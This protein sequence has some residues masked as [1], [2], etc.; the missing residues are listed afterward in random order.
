[1]SALKSHSTYFQN[2]FMIILGL[3]LGICV[4]SL[5]GVLVVLLVARF[6]GRRVQQPL[7]RDVEKGAATTTSNIIRIRRLYAVLVGVFLF[8][9]E[10]SI[11]VVF[12]DMASFYLLEPAVA[13]VLALVCCAPTTVSITLCFS[14]FHWPLSLLAITGECCLFCKTSSSPQ[15][16][17]ESPK[18]SAIGPSP[19]GVDLEMSTQ[20]KFREQDGDDD[21]YTL[22]G[23]SVGSGV[24]T[25]DSTPTTNT[26]IQHQPRSFTVLELVGIYWKGA[27]SA[28]IRAPIHFMCVAVSTSAGLAFVVFAM[29]GMCYCSNPSE[30]TT[31]LSRKASTPL[32]AEDSFCHLYALLGVDHSRMRVVGHVVVSGEDGPSGTTIRT[33]K[34]PL[35]PS[36]GGRYQE[37]DACD[38]SDVLSSPVSGTIVY[39]AHISEDLRYLAHHLLTGLEPT[40]VYKAVVEI[41][42]NNGVTLQKTLVFNTMPSRVNDTTTPVHFISGG[43]YYSGP[44]G[45]AMIHHVISRIPDLSFVYVGGD[46]SYSNNIRTCYRRMDY[47][48]R[49][50]SS[51]KRSI[52]GA[53]LPLLVIPGNHESGGYLKEDDNWSRYFFY[54]EY[55]PHYDD[56][57]PATLLTTHHM[58]YV[59][60]NLAIIGLDSGLMETVESQ[61][62]YLKTSL[63]AAMDGYIPPTDLSVAATQIPPATAPFVIVTYHNPAYPSLRPFSDPQSEDVRNLF[64]PQ[65]D[66]Y[67]VPLVLEF[68]DHAYKRTTPV[69]QNDVAA[70]GKGAIYVGDGGIGIDRDVQND[71]PAEHND[72][73]VQRVAS[74]NVQAITIFPNR[75]CRLST[76]DADGDVIDEIYIN[77]QII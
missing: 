8:G 72:L 29:Y 68:H 23:A 1:M 60:A 48:V 24:A 6:C 7:A 77:K 75:T 19:S 69:F 41:T 4:M 57:A 39:H 10:L 73:Y 37:T 18:C 62:D 15:E 28:C 66:R 21:F 26:K 30:F 63:T 51:L 3:A 11:A 58:H 50:F 36:T 47:F 55:F 32:C 20:K 53:N 5:V 27:L 16:S 61:V 14:P 71:R 17:E 42:L 44:R 38:P 35:S 64:V 54:L 25:K 12:A 52:D 34:M 13:L 45:T 2:A 70:T 33:C 9:V 22:S 43:D 31:W 40:R 67:R 49:E 65:V 46:L 74:Y 59:G 56:D 76:F